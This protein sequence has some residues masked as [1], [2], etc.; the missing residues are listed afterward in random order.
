LLELLATRLPRGPFG[1]WVMIETASRT[2]VGAVGFVAPPGRGRA[3]ELGY[4]VLPGWRRRGYAREAASAIV[5][6]AIVD[7]ALAQAGVEAVHA[8]C[9]ADNEPSSR[10]L[11]ALGFEC[12]ARSG[13]ELHWRCLTDS[14]S[15]R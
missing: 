1:P 3:V 13:G 14:R 2:V 11:E 4:S 7:W 15:R 6:S 5:A 8:R 9:S 12:T 10:V